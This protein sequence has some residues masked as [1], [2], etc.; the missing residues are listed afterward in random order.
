MTAAEKNLFDRQ[1]GVLHGLQ[2]VHPHGAHLPQG[3]H[4]V[5]ELGEDVVHL[6]HGVVLAE[7]QA[8]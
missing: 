6:L 5:W 7:A 1:I 4:D 8:Q 2:L 3:T